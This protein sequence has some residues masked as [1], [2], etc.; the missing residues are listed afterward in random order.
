MQNLANLDFKMLNI[1]MSNND[2]VKMSRADYLNIV[3]GENY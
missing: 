2:S 3:K 1:T